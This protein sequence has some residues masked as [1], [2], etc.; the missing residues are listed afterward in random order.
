MNKNL[1]DEMEIV[2]KYLH[3]IRM[4]DRLAIIAGGCPREWM[5]NNLAVDVDFYVQLPG[6]DIFSLISLFNNILGSK[7]RV[8]N[9]K[10]LLYYSNNSSNSYIKHIL[11]YKI[12]GKVYQIIILNDHYNRYDLIRDFNISSS[13]IY[14][15]TSLNTKCSYINN[16][17]KENKTLY[18]Y[19]HYYE[20]FANF[21][22]NKNIIYNKDK[23]KNTKYLSKII[24]RYLNYKFIPLDM[25]YI[26]LDNVVTKNLLKI[27][28]SKEVIVNNS[29]NKII[30]YPPF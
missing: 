2:A 19:V 18:L 10:N 28:Y 24:N 27:E 8:T 21:L 29:K 11:N 4:L 22:V 16:T 6:L 13:Q 30:D 12:E 15:T 23:Y 26:S 17:H 20:H 25:D 9:D 14:L 1:I 7:N 3:K 5:L